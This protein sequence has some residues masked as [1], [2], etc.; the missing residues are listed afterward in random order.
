M[1]VVFE[2]FRMDRRTRDMLIAARVICKAPIEITQ[3]SYNNS[4]GASAGTHS[5]GGALDLRA[6]TRTAAERKEIVSCLRKVGFAAWLR[7]PSQGNWPYHVHAVAIGCSDLSYQAE[8][9]VQSYK[10]GRNGLANNGAD[11][12]PRTWVSWTW[13]K[14]KATYPDLLTEDEVQQADIDKIAAAVKA[15]VAPVTQAYSAFNAKNLEQQLRT[16][17][18]NLEGLEQKYTVAVNDFA[19]QVD[20]ANDADVAK[21]ATA[22]TALT[23]KVVELTA[24]VDA[25]PKA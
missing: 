12:G 14:Y 7:T 17:F 16:L 9:Q 8:Q 5:G 22:V 6:T 20:A 25:L 21:L 3:G 24:K 11:D 15:E 18:T 4:V 2:G 19:R 10:A 23:G 1:A 13:E